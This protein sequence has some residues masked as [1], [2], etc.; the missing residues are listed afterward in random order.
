MEVFDFN[1]GLSIYLHNFDR[2]TLYIDYVWEYNHPTIGFVGLSFSSDSRY[3]YDSKAKEL[4]QM[5][6]EDS[7]IFMFPDLADTKP[8]EMGFRI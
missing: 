2:S 4:F 1:V 3:L 6:Y 7:F 5:G 8:D